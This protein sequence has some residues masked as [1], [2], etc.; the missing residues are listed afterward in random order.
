MLL[1]PN[2]GN[3]TSLDVSGCTDL[4]RIDIFDIILS[5]YLA[6]I[7]ELKMIA[8]PVDDD[9][10]DL[11]AHQLPNLRYLDLGITKIT[12]VGVKALAL[13]TGSK[14]ER[15][16]INHCRSISIDAVEWAR[17]QGINVSFTF[18]D[19]GLKKCKRILV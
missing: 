17:A 5:G 19:S 6:N 18:S 11:L 14:L 12:G 1:D 13:K 9:I 16:S 7:V 8:L 15:L 10:A 2:K 4:A 3:M